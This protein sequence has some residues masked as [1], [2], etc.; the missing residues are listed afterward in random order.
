MYA[1]QMQ[2]A[3]TPTEVMSAYVTQDMKDLDSHAGVSCV[4][5]VR[6]RIY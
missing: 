3:L 5:T 4:A 2:T 1:I 6:K